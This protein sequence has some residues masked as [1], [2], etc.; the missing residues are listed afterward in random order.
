[1]FRIRC[2]RVAFVATAALAAGLLGVP[3][4][5]AQ[6]TRVDLTGPFVQ[7]GG[8]AG[9][10]T[11]ESGPVGDSHAGYGWGAGAGLGISAHFAVVAGYAIY[12]VRDQTSRPYNLEQSEFG[13]R[14]R[15]GG[16]SAPVVFFLEGG[17]AIRQ[18]DLRTSE[19]FGTLPPA[20]ADSVTRVT[21]WAGWFGPGVQWYAGGSR[22]IALDVAVAWGWGDWSKARVQGRSLKL[23]DPIGFTTLRLRAGLAVVLF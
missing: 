16:T 9:S 14:T 18:A 20:G 8:V 15:V 11:G 19:L 1:M 10:V 17:G 12:R 23:P 3:R 4:A 6:S 21:G 22:R 7:F 5:S 2:T 13:W